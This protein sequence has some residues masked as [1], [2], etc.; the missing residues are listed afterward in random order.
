MPTVIRTPLEKK[1]P[2]ASLLSHTG[3][4]R[5]EKHGD[6]QQASDCGGEPWRISQ[7]QNDTA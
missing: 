6:Q 4:E 3:G 5:K 1:N 7:R 2:K